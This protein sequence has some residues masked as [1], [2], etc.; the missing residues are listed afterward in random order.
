VHI[1]GDLENIEIVAPNGSY[2]EGRR[3]FNKE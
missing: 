3:N 1:L 2:Y